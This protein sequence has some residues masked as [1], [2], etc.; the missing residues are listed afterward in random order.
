[1]TL[2]AVDPDYVYLTV[3]FSQLGR[4]EFPFGRQATLADAL[5]SDGSFSSETAN[6]SQI[7]MLHSART[8]AA[9]VTAL[10][11]DACDISSV[12]LATRLNLRAN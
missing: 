12:V 6:P 8:D 9:M 2:D 1:M 7:Y 5:Y 11:L 4:F 3:E 10:H